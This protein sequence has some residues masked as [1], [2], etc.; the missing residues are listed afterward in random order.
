M[1]QYLSNEQTGLTGN[2]TAIPVGY[3]APGSVYGGRF[4]RMRATINLASQTTAD[5][6]NLGTLPA[7]AVF[8]YGVIVSSVSLGT[9]T[10]AFGVAGTPAKY[11]AAAVF[12]AVDTPTMFGPAAAAAA[13]GL[14]ADETVIATIGAANLPAAGTLVVDLYYSAAN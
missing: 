9:S 4:K 10:L 6:L 7:G 13:A 3:R 12:T 14:A 2:Q 5:T 8:A 1:P 11:R